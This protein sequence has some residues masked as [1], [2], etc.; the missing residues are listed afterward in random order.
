LFCEYFFLFISEKLI[1][2]GFAVMDKLNS[3]SN[4]INPNPC[5]NL[6]QIENFQESQI[7]ISALLKR[8]T[9]PMISAT[10]N[11]ITTKKI[12]V[13]DMHRKIILG[14]RNFCPQEPSCSEISASEA[15][16]DA[17]KSHEIPH[18]SVEKSKW[19]KKFAHRF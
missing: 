13:E 6:W 18:L 7:Q 4:S 11:G 16:F 14:V 9:W 12:L 5:E 1:L 19:V 3:A 17:K 8:V 10:K 2:V 15:I